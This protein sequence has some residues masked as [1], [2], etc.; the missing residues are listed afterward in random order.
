MTQTTTS[1]ESCIENCRDCQTTC[2]QMLTD[3]CLK[4][5]G[6]HVEQQHVKTM[7]DCIAACAACVDF[8]SRNSEHHALYCKACA[9]ICRACADSCEKVGNMDQCV[10]A[11]RKCAETCESM[12]A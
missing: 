10:E 1:H 9:E 7:L 11:C 12:A 4:E 2:S 3:H 6:S 5:G 8:M